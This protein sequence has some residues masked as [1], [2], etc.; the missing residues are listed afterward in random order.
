MIKLKLRIKETPV[1]WVIFLINTLI[2][3][4]TNIFKFDNISFL[5]L[6]YDE[7]P[8]RWYTVFTYSLVHMAWYHIIINMSILILIGSWVEKLIGTKRY[9]I[10][11]LVSALS[12]GIALIL[13]KSSGIGFSAVGYAII[14][15]YYLAYPLERE[16]PFKFP[17]II[18]PILLMISTILAIIFNWLSI[19]A[20]FSHIAGAV[21]GALLLLFFYKKH[22]EI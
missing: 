22:K 17:N 8:Q 6:I 7:L 14:F 21:V 10:L 18:F 16:L 1:T 4:I 20:H 2:F 12:G 13:Q 15:Y 3:I 5:A 11:I 9:L 19:I